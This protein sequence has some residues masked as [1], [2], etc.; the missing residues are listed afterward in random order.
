M[1]VYIFLILAIVIAILFIL[2]KEKIKEG[3]LEGMIAND[4]SKCDLDYCNNYT[5]LKNVLC[6]GNDCT[7]AVHAERC[8][9]H[10]F[11]YGKNEKRT[12]FPKLNGNLCGL[13]SQ[14]GMSSITGDGY[15]NDC[16]DYTSTFGPYKNG[17]GQLLTNNCSIGYQNVMNNCSHNNTCST[18]SD[19]HKRKACNIGFDLGKYKQ[20]T[21]ELKAIKKQGYIELVGN[22]CVIPSKGRKIDIKDSQGKDLIFTRDYTL[23]FEINP[24]PIDDEQVNGKD[25]RNIF[26]RVYDES[27]GWPPPRGSRVPA[28]FFWPK[29]YQGKTGNELYIRVN[30]KDQNG[31]FDDGINTKHIPENKWTK[32]S[33]TLKDNKLSYT[34]SGGVSDDSSKT[35]ISE[36]TDSKEQY[37]YRQDIPCKLYLGVPTFYSTNAKIRN[38]KWTNHPDK[39]CFAKLPTGCAN[40]LDVLNKFQHTEYQNK[41]TG[42][43]E[44]GWD[45]TGTDDDCHNN[46]KKAFNDDC[47]KN[48]AMTVVSDKKPKDNANVGWIGLDP[49]AEQSSGIV[50]RQSEY[51]Q[52]EQE[53]RQHPACN[54][55][56]WVKETKKCDLLKS[57]V[58][59]N[60]DT[61]WRFSKLWENFRGMGK[62]EGFSTRDVSNNKKYKCMKPNGEEEY[63]T[64]ATYNNDTLTLAQKAYAKRNYPGKQPSHYACV[65][66]CP[67]PYYCS[68]NGDGVM[69]NVR[70][71]GLE[72]VSSDSFHKLDTAI[73]AGDNITHHNIIFRG[74]TDKGIDDCERAC[75]DDNSC[76]GYEFLKK[77][78][79][80]SKANICA[81]V[82]DWKDMGKTFRLEDG[83][84]EE[85]YK[86]KFT[87]GVKIYDLKYGDI[88]TMNNQYL[89]PTGKS[90][91]GFLDIAGGGDY[92]GKPHNARYTFQTITTPDAPR[93]GGGSC[94]WQ[95]I[96]AEG[97]TGTVKNNDIVYLHCV[98]KKRGF[99]STNKYTGGFL[100]C[101]TDL[102]KRNCGNKGYL[103]GTIDIDSPPEMCKWKIRIPS[104]DNPQNIK[105]NSKIVLFSVD[106]HSK[107]R[108]SRT[109]APGEQPNTW[110]FLTCNWHDESRKYLDTT[111]ERTGQ[112]AGRKPEMQWKLTIIERPENFTTSFNNSELSGRPIMS[113]S[114]IDTTWTYCADENGVCNING[115]ETIRYGETSSSNY[116]DKVF[117]TVGEDIAINCNNSVFTDPIVGTVKKCWKKPVTTDQT[118]GYSISD[119][120]SQ[121]ASQVA[122]VIGFK[123]PKKVTE[124]SMVDKGFSWSQ[125]KAKCEEK[126]QN[127]ATRAE[128]LGF[129]KKKHDGN[130]WTP[131]ADG[132]NEWLQVGQRK[133]NVTANSQ[134]TSDYGLL[135]KE[136]DDVK[137]ATGLITEEW[138][139]RDKLLKYYC[140]GAYETSEQETKMNTCPEN[141]AK[142]TKITGNCA[143][144]NPI[145]TTDGKYYKQCPYT[146]LGPQDTGYKDIGPKDSSE[147][148]DVNSHGCR[149]STQ[150][151]PCGNELV[152]TKGKFVEQNV[153]GV[154]K[155]FFVESPS[156]SNSFSSSS[157]TTSSDSS[158]YKCNAAFNEQ[159]GFPCVSGKCYDAGEKCDK[160]EVC[161]SGCCN[162]SKCVYIPESEYKSRDKLD[163][164]NRRF[165]ELMGRGGESK[166]ETDD[167]TV[168]NIQSN[169][170]NIAD[171]SQGNM[172]T[173]ITNAN[174]IGMMD[175][176]LDDYYKRR[177][178]NNSTENRLGGSDDAMKYVKKMPRDNNGKVSFFNSVWTLFN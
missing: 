24:G 106:A 77:D 48:D 38:M 148:Y 157:S 89:P 13:L 27:P 18:I 31:N 122:Q 85:F 84:P 123:N 67:D 137:N 175:M 55:I 170:Q 91:Y 95:I 152:E 56:R 103:M 73:Y 2:K 130:S 86:D 70:N 5:D 17:S 58:E 62:K 97:K 125:V 34:L 105:T 133:S 110:I 90:T 57:G 112:T 139:N 129:L 45:W 50:I 102:T 79:G 128:I 156:T 145:E 94:L 10:W 52:C 140:S 3:L 98:K 136:I 19:F 138:R 104:D 113:Q 117:G 168:Q 171:T 147:K 167:E 37:Y 87:S 80:T 25:W 134:G 119:T 29:D 118:S 7:T 74:A 66:G 99:F 169:Q 163:E 159:Q 88:F 22:E 82:H 151:L 146:C 46:R 161:K 153:G 92:E 177:L 158:K 116:I 101:R 20:L 16:N 23:E 33:I 75:V 41:S 107:N 43:I 54:N 108:G 120:A 149:T 1:N 59:Q 126:S 115:K 93:Q 15:I 44:G 36:G 121:V 76:L 172:F 162:D 141:C 65:Q 135:H 164:F 47:I 11:E 166:T 30:T 35:V 160:N 8:R 4:I 26:S 42:W 9:N 154:I 60:K 51:P 12:K 144:G 61:R 40:P 127:M 68:E 150:C 143:S 178:L 28:I 132:N 173:D 83:E 131:V 49:K 78:W 72:N 81:L 109:I 63:S 64:F 39:R 53:C 14:H 114:N 111:C 6:A 165:N 124:H 32:V 69:K 155:R 176:S 21:K 100:C 71:N 174:D 96:S 142:P